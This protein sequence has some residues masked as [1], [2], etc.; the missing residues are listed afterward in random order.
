MSMY[1]DKRSISEFQNFY[2]WC[3]KI[4]HNMMYK[5]K[6]TKKYKILKSEQNKISSILDTYT[7][8]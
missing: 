4:L 6:N 8:L 5:I 2:F 7:Y 3:L 1:Y